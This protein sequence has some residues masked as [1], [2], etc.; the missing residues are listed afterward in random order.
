[1]FLLSTDQQRDI[2]IRRGVISASIHFFPIIKPLPTS[3][4]TVC[5]FRSGGALH[6]PSTLV[7]ITPLWPSWIINI[8]FRFSLTW[9]HLEKWESG[10][11]ILQAS[12]K[13]KENVYVQHMG[14]Q[15]VF[16]MKWR[17]NW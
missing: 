12:D 6:D 1:M 9:R 4:T 11:Y 16:H 2:P 5:G 14:D 10:W 7:T 17:W 3:K 8:T 13:T 15:Y